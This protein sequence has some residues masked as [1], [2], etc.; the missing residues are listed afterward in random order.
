MAHRPYDNDIFDAFGVELCLQISV[1]MLPAV[2]WLIA[3]G[4]A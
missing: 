3:R 4:N 2:L 1:S